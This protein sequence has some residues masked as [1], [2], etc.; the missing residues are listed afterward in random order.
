MIR[1]IQSRSLRDDVL[2]ITSAA[3]PCLL[4]ERLL[5]FLQLRRRDSTLIQSQPLELDR[6][7]QFFH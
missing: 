1:L 5:Q 6:G 2:K 4:P 7:N 3:L